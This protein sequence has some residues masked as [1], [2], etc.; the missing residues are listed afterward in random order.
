MS[1]IKTWEE[2]TICDNFPLQKVMKNQK[3]C[4]QLI[5]KILHID[6]T[7]ITFPETEKQIDVNYDKNKLMSITIAKA[8]A[9]MCMYMMTRDESMTLKCNAA[10]MITSS[11]NEPDIIKP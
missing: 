6:I 4:K 8:S 7:Q 10:T 11:P 5:E 1:K 3:I 2:L 9:S